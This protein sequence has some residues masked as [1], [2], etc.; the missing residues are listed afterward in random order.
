MKTS[1]RELGMVGVRLVP[2]RKL[3]SEKELTCAED[4]VEVLQEELSQHDREVFCVLHLNAK[5]V[6]LSASITSVGELT[7]TLV[8][9][10]EVFKSAVLASAAAIILLHNHPSGDIKP[11]REDIET[12]KKL[13]HCG[14]LMGIRV[15][16]HIICGN[17]EKYYS[18]GRDGMNA[19]E[20]E[21]NI[22]FDQ[23]DS[24]Q[25]PVVELTE[26]SN[27]SDAVI[28][29]KI[30]GMEMEIPLT[31]DEMTRVYFAQQRMWDEAYVRSYLEEKDYSMESRRDF[32]AEFGFS[33]KSMLRAKTAITRIAA[34]MRISVDKCGISD[35]DGLEVALKEES[36]RKLQRK[37]NA[38]AMER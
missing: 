23:L 36:A 20:C 28:L 3:Y 9:P 14:R 34:G 7:S 11:S 37:R 1:K 27:M 29:R 33:A 16:D 30:N 12:T 35:F 10:R 4:A 17:R 13:V 15:L 32:Q 6:P 5:G 24:V 38:K 22:F 18:M 21:S 25:E 19:L 31:P 8:H 26:N 2:E